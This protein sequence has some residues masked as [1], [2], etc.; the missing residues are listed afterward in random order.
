MMH[1]DV[2][3]A[4]SG[5]SASLASH[6][7]ARVGV[8]V[9][10]VDRIDRSRFKVGEVLPGAASRLLRSAGIATP[11]VSGVHSRIVGSLSSWESPDLVASDALYSLDGP[12]WRLN[13]AHFDAELRSAAENSGASFRTAFVKRAYREG[14]CW[15]LTLDDGG[16]VR[17]RWAVDATGRKSVLSRLF[18]AKRIRDTFLIAVYARSEKTAT[19]PRSQRTVI[20]ATLDGW[21]YAAYLPSGR[22]LAGIHVSPRDAARLRERNEWCKAWSRT[23]H[24]SGLFPEMRSPLLLPPMDAGGAQTYPLYGDGWL[25]CGDAAVCFEPLSSQGILTALYSGRL[26]ADFIL[27]RLTRRL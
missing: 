15:S 8:Q 23:R 5:P 12:S 24:V 17:A 20:E 26:A 4:G 14:S 6:L 21:W 16:A 7:L 27:R 3:V 1:W 10:V 2:V 11:D 13:R 25:A 9:L 22:V 19:G 18:G